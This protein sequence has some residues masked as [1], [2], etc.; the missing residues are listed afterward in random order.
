MKILNC[1]DKSKYGKYSDTYYVYI[2]KIK[3]VLVNSVAT[4]FG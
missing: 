4:I 3:H 1:T 2:P